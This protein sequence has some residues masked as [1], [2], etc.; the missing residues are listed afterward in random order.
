MRCL[1]RSEDKGPAML[2]LALTWH[3]PFMI[4]V[5]AIVTVGV[6]WSFRGYRCIYRHA[7]KSRYLLRFGVPIL[8]AFLAGLTWGFLLQVLVGILFL[9]TPLA[10][11]GFL[12]FR[13]IF[14]VF[15][16]NRE[17]CSLDKLELLACSALMSSPIWCGLIVLISGL[18]RFT[19]G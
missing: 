5:L 15:K 11:L 7:G 18:C 6:I 9:Y 14:L 1:E 2:L 10:F 4:I 12:I 16:G 8:L 19:F 17:P 3:L 13:T